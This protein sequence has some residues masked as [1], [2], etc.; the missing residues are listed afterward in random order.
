MRL[1]YIFP[2][3]R[4]AIDNFIAGLAVAKFGNNATAIGDG[5]LLK[6]ILENLDEIAAFI[7]MLFKLFGGI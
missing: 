5:D 4:V 3:A 6:L 1:A 2:K 7:A